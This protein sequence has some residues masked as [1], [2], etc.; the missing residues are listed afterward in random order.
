MDVADRVPQSAAAVR[1]RIAWAAALLVA[2]GAVALAL[3]AAGH[4]SRTTF[5]APPEFGATRWAAVGDAGDAVR[6]WAEAEQRGRRLLLLTGRW[7]L[8]QSMRLDALE[9]STARGAAPDLVDANTAIMAT[10]RTGIARDLQVVMPPDAWQRRLD[11][12]AAAKELVRGERAFSVPYH[13]FRRRFALP[14][15]LE[16][17]GEP[18]LVLVEPSFFAPGAPDDPAAWLRARGVEVD[19]GLVALADPT[20]TPDQLER[21]AAFARHAGAVAVE[22]AR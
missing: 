21:A 18:A 20:A 2:A 22:V 3:E 16:P 7:A 1:A 6:V 13:G 9:A 15:A 19:L 10:A 8:V 5:V 4:A 12:V 11:E 17:P 14:G